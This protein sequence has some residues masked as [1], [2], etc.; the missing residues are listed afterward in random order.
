MWVEKGSISNTHT[1][2]SL[3]KMLVYCSG[4]TLLTFSVLTKGGDDLD[5]N[6]VQSSRVRTGR[7]I[8]GYTLPPHNSR[9]ERR[10]VEKLSIEG[11]FLASNFQPY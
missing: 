2:L 7:S 3:F 10:A 6:Y 11:E 4:C 1:R 8:K 5:P 9:G